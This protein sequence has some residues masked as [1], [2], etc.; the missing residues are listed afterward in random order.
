LVCGVAVGLAE[1]DVRGVRR[2]ELAHLA[3]LAPICREVL[4]TARATIFA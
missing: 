4:P 1:I 2:E 3:I